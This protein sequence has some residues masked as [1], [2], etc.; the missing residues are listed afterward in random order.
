[1]PASPYDGTPEGNPTPVQI[2]TRD[3]SVEAETADAKTGSAEAEANKPFATIEVS[4][5]T[6]HDHT[7]PLAIA[8]D[9]LQH[10]AIT[11]NTNKIASHSA[12][13]TSSLTV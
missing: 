11:K 13:T 6:T 1:M 9:T 4:P 2:G 7:G 5:E 10:N 8:D 12:L 3:L